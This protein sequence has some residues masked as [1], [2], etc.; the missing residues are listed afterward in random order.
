[1]K[2]EEV[3]VATCSE[4]GTVMLWKPLQVIIFYTLYYN[5]I[6]WLMFKCTM[7]VWSD[8]MKASTGLYPW[9]YYV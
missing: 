8:V 7:H 1:M 4:D 3:I 6:N 2:M 5:D 9:Y